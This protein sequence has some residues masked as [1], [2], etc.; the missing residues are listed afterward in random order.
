[1]KKIIQV[2]E[3]ENEGLEAFLNKK[4]FVV[5]RSYFYAGILTGINSECIL[6]EDARFVLQSGS[7]EGSKFD[8]SEKVKGGKIYVSKNAIE[9]FFESHA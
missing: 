2:T 5:C 4:I 7:F 8:E 9:S 6:I 1:M 3:V